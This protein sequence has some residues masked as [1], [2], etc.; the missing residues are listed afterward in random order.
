MVDGVPAVRGVAVLD[1]ES[2]A[3]PQMLPAG[4]NAA[5]EI[6]GGR[7]EDALLVPVE[8]LRELGPGEYAVFVMVDGEPTLRVV[9]VGLMDFTYA[10]IISGLEPGDVVSTGV[11]ETE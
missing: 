10:E 7:T 4:L 6:I 1:A 8:A 11:V 9:E 3:R 2:A 5:V